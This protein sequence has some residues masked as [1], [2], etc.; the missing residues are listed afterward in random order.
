[1]GIH[2][3]R[4]GH[5]GIHVS[6]VDRS[7]DFYRKVLGLK[8]TGRWGPP[9]FGCPICFM[10]INDKHHDVVLF[11]LSEDMR[12]AGITSTDSRIRRA[13]GRADFRCPS[14][15]SG[16]LRRAR[17]RGAS[18]CCLT[19][20]HTRDWNRAARRRKSLAGS[21]FRLRRLGGTRAH[22]ESPPNRQ[23]CRPPWRQ[24]PKLVL[25]AHPYASSRASVAAGRPLKRLH[26]LGNFFSVLRK[27][28]SLRVSR[29]KLQSTPRDL[30]HQSLARDVARS[31]C[32][33][34]LNRDVSRSANAHDPTKN[35]WQVNVRLRYCQGVGE[36]PLAPLRR[37][38]RSSITSPQMFSSAIRPGGLD[39]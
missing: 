17:C 18:H 25:V 19:G 8:I 23:M 1:M 14:F 3:S 5:I 28:Q 35:L 26:M 4:V 33:T 21:G 29:R 15:A 34:N 27:I 22:V 11:E 37:P 6:D 24:S 9:D 12:K 10:R 2:L 39:G 32:A 7:I 36:R 38:S 16:R 13:P 31:C 30:L 20:S